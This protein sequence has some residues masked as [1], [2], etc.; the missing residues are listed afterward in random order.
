LLVAH[1]HAVKYDGENKETV[2][3]AHAYNREKLIERGEFDP[4]MV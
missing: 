2:A 4:D 3:E 1:N